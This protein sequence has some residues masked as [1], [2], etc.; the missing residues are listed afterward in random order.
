MQNAQIKVEEILRES[1][2][3]VNEQ[4]PPGAELTFSRDISLLPG[5]NGLDSLATVNLYASIE[6]RIEECFGVSMILA[7]ETD[8]ASEDTDPLRSV[9]ALMDFLTRWLEEHGT[10]QTDGT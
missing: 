1:V 4:L 8:S 9:G 6:Q 10:R 2:A 7:E 3:E 5:S